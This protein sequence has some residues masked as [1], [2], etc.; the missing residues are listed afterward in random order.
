VKKRSGPNSQLAR[1]GCEIFV[2]RPF[3]PSLRQP[4]GRYRR[5]R[6]GVLHF[7]TTSKGAAHYWCLTPFSCAKRKKSLRSLSRT[8]AFK[9]RSTGLEPAASNVTGWRSNQLS[10]DPSLALR[11][12]RRKTT[13]FDPSF[14]ELHATISAD[15]CASLQPKTENS[16]FRFTQTGQTQRSTLV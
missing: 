15:C 4:C 1:R 2:G 14:Q 16:G 12:N 7:L 5:P 11:L 13:A 8:Q 10:Y 6:K 3:R 9:A